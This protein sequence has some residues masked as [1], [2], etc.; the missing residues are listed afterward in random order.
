MSFRKSP[1]FLLLAILSL[2][3]VI[4]WGCS[5]KSNPVGPDPEPNPVPSGS[6]E[7]VSLGVDTRLND[8][9][10]TGDQFVAVGGEV[11]DAVIFT[12]RDGY[13]WERQQV[14]AEFS[15]WGVTSNDERIVA[16]GSGNVVYS[17]EDGAEWTVRRPGSMSGLFKVVWAEDRFVAVGGYGGLCAGYMMTS[18]DG[19]SWSSPTVISP[20]MLRNIVWSGEQFV[21]VG[22]GGTTIASKDGLRWE[23]NPIDSVTEIFSIVHSPLGYVT[24]GY[25]YVCLS[26]DG[27]HWNRQEAPVRRY[28]YDLIWADGRVIA[29]G[30][31][32]ENRARVFESG[33]CDT[34]CE[35]Y[36]GAESNLTAL[37]FSPELD[38]YVVVGFGGELAFFRTTEPGILADR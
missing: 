34:W 13:S 29:V 37:A 17:S 18:P 19:L 8:V 7:S 5:E 28:L 20:T 30:S 25:R 10:W 2:L 11:G 26:D 22:M 6:W 14:P 23:Y 32:S 31:P 3:L 38:T 1:M 15:L 4:G 16:V 36:D 21:A 33:S 24:V 12:S 9:C 35:L 27:I